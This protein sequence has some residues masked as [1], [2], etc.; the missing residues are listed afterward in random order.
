MSD[1]NI[2]FIPDE[3]T[4]CKRKTFINF[5]LFKATEFCVRYKNIVF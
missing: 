4:S 1:L 3:Q 2:N 5:K